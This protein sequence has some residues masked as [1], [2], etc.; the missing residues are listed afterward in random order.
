MGKARFCPVLLLLGWRLGSWLEKELGYRRMG[1][2]YR[3]HERSSP[4]RSAR[5]VAGSAV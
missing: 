3:E 1:L 4:A 5:A 2:E